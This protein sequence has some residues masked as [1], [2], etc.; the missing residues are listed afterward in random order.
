MRRPFFVLALLLTLLTTAS[1]ITSRAAETANGESANG[2]AAST[3]K[4][5]EEPIPSIL[6]GVEHVMVNITKRE[7]PSDEEWQALHDEPQRGGWLG[8]MSD[9]KSKT[10]AFMNTRYYTANSAEGTLCSY[11][12]M[13][14][15]KRYDRFGQIEG[16]K[17]EIDPNSWK[18]HYVLNAAALFKLT[19]S[20]FL[21][22][23]GV[24]VEAAAANKQQIEVTFL[25]VNIP[26]EDVVRSLNSNIEALEYL[27]AVHLKREAYD[28]ETLKFG[29]SG[30]P[31][32]PK[33]VLSNVVMLN[34]TF[35]HALDASLDGKLYSQI[36][37]DGVELKVTQQN[38]EQMRLLSPVVRCYRTYSVEFKTDANGDRIFRTMRD[39]DGSIHTVPQVFDL[40]PDI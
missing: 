15:D 30:G 21:E 18:E 39:K 22:F 7:R 29:F 25:G 10:I 34:G 19:G 28:R 27:H 32:S 9:F 24:G 20:R 16:V 14:P 40:T 3:E 23:A 11:G 33:V 38:G 12:K 2:E 37:N 8:G 13:S 5:A 1:R 26:K 36:I 17:F 35:A 6:E 31:P 4:R